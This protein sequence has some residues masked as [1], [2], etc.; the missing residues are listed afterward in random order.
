MSKNAFEATAFFLAGGLTMVAYGASM[1]EGFAST[2]A[3]VASAPN[4]GERGPGWVGER[5]EPMRLAFVH[6]APERQA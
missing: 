3:P 5:P 4:A 2:D 1:R 6:R